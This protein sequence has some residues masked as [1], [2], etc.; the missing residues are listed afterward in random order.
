MENKNLHILIVDDD[1]RIRSLL[2]DYLSKNHYIVSTAENSE[3]A[4]IK[5][6]YI[7]FDILILDPNKDS[8]AVLPISINIFGSIILFLKPLFPITMAL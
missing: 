1:D 8:I 7:K 6:N 5:M 3:Q 2:K 4:K